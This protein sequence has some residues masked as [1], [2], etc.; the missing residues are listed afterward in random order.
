MTHLHLEIRMEIKSLQVILARLFGTWIL[1]RDYTRP[2]FEVFILLLIF[3]CLVIWFLDSAIRPNTISGDYLEPLI[4]DLSYI[5]AILLG[6]YISGKLKHLRNITPPPTLEEREDKTDRLW[7]KVNHSFFEIGWDPSIDNRKL[8]TL[9]YFVK[10]HIL[11]P[12]KGL[13]FVY[14]KLLED[15]ATENFRRLSYFGPP[16]YIHVEKTG[17]IADTNVRNIVTNHLV[18]FTEEFPYFKYFF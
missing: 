17:N 11:C 5:T 18:K 3:V 4:I 16:S 7:H 14:E 9:K 2:F 1:A 15:T 10:Y 8:E 13:G 6:T 12:I